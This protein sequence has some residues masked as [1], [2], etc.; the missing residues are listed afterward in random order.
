[1][2]REAEVTRE[3]LA[4]MRAQINRLMDALQ[5]RG[6]LSRSLNVLQWVDEMSDYIESYIAFPLD[7]AVW[8][9]SDTLTM[10]D[11]NSDSSRNSIDE[12]GL[13][14]GAVKEVEEAL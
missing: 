12:S 7:E 1:M 3:E 6:E 5:R 10:R 4:N 14:K 13:G 9:R 8:S 11:P 2:R